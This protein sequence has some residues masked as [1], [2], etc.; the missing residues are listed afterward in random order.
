MAKSA[1]VLLALV[2]VSQPST[3]AANQ[4]S[5]IFRFHTDEFWLNLHHFLYVLGRAQA[6]MPDASR[7]A[8]VGAP[9]DSDAG[10]ANLT[11]DERQAWREAVAFYA[12]GPSRKDALFDAPMSAAA[13]ALADAG[14]REGLAG[15]DT[16][17]ASWR[18]QLEQAAPV[19][20]KGWW[21]SHRAANAG[22][23]DDI[24]SLVDRRGAA[25]LAFVTRVYG[26]DWPAEGYPV[27]FSAWANWAGAYST[28]GGVI[29]VS[30]T[31]RAARG[32]AGLEIAFHEG[33]HQWDRQV[34]TL[35]FGEARRTGKRLPPNLSHA[36]IFFTAGEAV[37]CVVPEHVPY[38]Q[39][40]GLWDTA[41]RGFREPLEETWKPYL[42]GHGTRDDAIAAVVKRV[43]G[44]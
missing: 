34:N 42:D 25:V 27:H 22:R 2:V 29:V 13:A 6:K 39:A 35:L 8:V 17:D 24:Q 40:N 16:I 7:E 37:R 28:S 44:S 9:A 4:R 15:V 26:M 1:V 14:D 41:Y 3:P 36:M 30:S 38:A 23:R 32:L 20:R 19:Y 43:G 21:P 5:P 33:M 11:A 10:L 18:A 12:N 31:D